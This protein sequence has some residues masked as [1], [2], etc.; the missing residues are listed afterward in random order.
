MALALGSA[1]G[2][3]AQ[4]SS[5]LDAPPRAFN[6]AGAPVPAAPPSQVPVDE[7]CRA[8]ERTAAGPE[9]TQVAAAGWKLEQFWPTQRAGDMVMIMA[10][11]QYDGM[12]RPNSFNAFAFVGGRYAGTVAP[13]P[14]AARTDGVLAAVPTVSADRRAVANFT[15]YAPTDPLCCPSRGQTRVTYRVDT[16]A[17]GPVLVPDQIVQVPPTP[18]PTPPPAAS[19]TPPPAPPPATPAARPTAPPAQLPRTGALALALLLPT[20]GGLTLAGLLLRRPSRRPGPTQHQ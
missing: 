20:A 12:C 18:S 3:A 6:T 15:R 9:E 1:G 16:P 14:M 4:A 19:P 13:A 8:Q 11:A 10:N 17:A 5:W 7:R 2:A